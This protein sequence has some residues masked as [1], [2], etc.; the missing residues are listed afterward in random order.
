MF[1]YLS[2][3]LS[4]ETPLYGGNGAITLGNVNTIAEGASSNTRH[5]SFSNHAGTHIDFPLHF[6]DVG[7]SLNNYQPSDWLFSNVHVVFVTV[8]ENQIIDEQ[9]ISLEDIPENTE[10]ILLVTGFS[11]YRKEKRYWNNNPGLAPSLA[12][13]LRKRCRNLRAIGF[14]FISLSSF[15]NRSLGRIAHREFLVNNDILVIEDMK[16]DDLGVQP[17][18][19]CIAQPLMVENADGGPISVIAELSND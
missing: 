5:Y 3:F 7:K 18:T 2:Y 9:Q 16:L 15:Q 14:D 6:S 1:I 19:R 11:K 13:L 12:L 17:I 10:L 4:E 8:K